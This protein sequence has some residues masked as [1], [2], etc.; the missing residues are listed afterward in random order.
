MLPAGKLRCKNASIKYYKI[1]YDRRQG[2]SGHTPL[3]THDNLPRPR[4][5]TTNDADLGEALSNAEIVMTNA[6]R[7]TADAMLGKFTECLRVMEFDGPYDPDLT[8]AQLTISGVRRGT[9]WWESLQM[10]PSAP[11]WS[12]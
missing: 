6:P 5:T 9:L 4:P 3:Y 2:K 11:K 12:N 1:A 7:F 8:A 10:L